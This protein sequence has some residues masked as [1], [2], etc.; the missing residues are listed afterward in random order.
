MKKDDEIEVLGFWW[1]LGYSENRLPGLLKFSQKNGAKLKVFHDEG[2]KKLLGWNKKYDIIY[3]IADNQVFT[4]YNCRQISF[5]ISNLSYQTFDSNYLF[6]HN[7]HYLE[8]KDDIQ[9]TNL[10]T[11]INNTNKFFRHLT[12]YNVDYSE[13]RYIIE[14]TPQRIDF[15]INHLLKGQIYMDNSNYNSY[16]ENSFELVGNIWFNI[17]SKDNSLLPLSIYMQEIN[18]L[19]MFFSIIIQGVCTYE[20]MEVQRPEFSGYMQLYS[21]NIYG[22]LSNRFMMFDFEYVKEKFSILLENWFRLSSEIPEVLNLFYG[23]YTSSQ[24][25]E[26]HFRETYIALEGL[27]QWKMKQDTQKKNVI[28]ILVGK[29]MKT[30]RNEVDNFSNIVTKYQNWGEVARKNR[31]YQ[32][33]LNE[34][35]KNDIVDNNELIRLTRKIQ[36]IILFYV[37]EELGFS[38]SEINKI[39]FNLIGHFKPKFF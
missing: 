30:R 19:R 31:H 12:S 16:S 32:M 14:E 38:D 15:N 37:L 36:A 9:F 3:G 23:T 22:E 20:G 10:C 24:F 18:N 7:T 1:I 27:F 11:Q 6:V 34:E 17:E 39:F 29:V 13:S 5:S 4:L 25:Y 8:H 35:Y 2:M 26:Y 21:Q 33:H 28:S